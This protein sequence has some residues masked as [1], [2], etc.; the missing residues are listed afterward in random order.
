MNSPD[1]RQIADSNHMLGAMTV[2]AVAMAT[3]AD[4]GGS[5]IGTHVVRLPLYVQTLARKLQSH[6]KFSAMLTDSFI[7]VLIQSAPLHDMGKIAIPDRILLKLSGL[8]PEESVVM[9]THTTLA[10]EVLE[11]IE[12]ALGYP[13]EQLATLKDMVLSHHEKW[14]GSGYPQGL[15]GDQIPVSA[16]LM[17]L[18]D[19]YDALVSDHVYK[20]GRSHEQA[21]AII[22]QERGGHFDPDMV[23]AFME[24][25][26]QF[27]VISRRHADTDLDIQKK[28]E[29]LANAIAENVE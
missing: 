27:D 25:E 11:Q 1:H 21:V 4:T 7:Q 28:L 22:F 10:R 2:A 8:T 18:A 29:Y 5:N 26:A 16:R 12:N 19:V 20:A 14:D 17:A 6:P 9:Q 15:C 13:S 3:L 23:D 24:I